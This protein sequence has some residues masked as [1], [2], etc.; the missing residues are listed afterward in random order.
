M[1]TKAYHRFINR[2]NHFDADLELIDIL[3]EAVKKNALTPRTGQVLFN[4]LNPTKHTTLAGRKN[5]RRSRAI[6]VSHLKRTVYS[7]YIKDLFEDVEQYLIELIAAASSSTLS[8]DRLVGEHKVSIEINEILKC[9]NWE[10]VVNL[11]ANNLF[12][13]LQET[14]KTVKLFEEIDK[15]LG[16]GIDKQILDD[17][18]PYLEM[19]HLLVHSDG[20]VDAKFCQSYPEFG[21]TAGQNLQMNYP[22]ISSARAKV[23]ALA[24]EM[25]SK[26][27]QK[28][29]IAA[30]YIHGN[31]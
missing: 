14:R 12:R 13:K 31:K 19:R 11:V 22:T 25:D 23:F 26:A 8:S 6:T 16:L 30:K 10:A 24:K 29:T 18:L 28:L 15:K 7:A 9:G 21:Y 20:K 27:T 4:H 2:A 3:S 5:N 1:I 17:A